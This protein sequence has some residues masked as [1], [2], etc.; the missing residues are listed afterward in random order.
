MK[1]LSYLNKYL[2]KYRGRLFLGFI[3]IL[4]GNLFNVLAPAVASDGIDFLIGALEQKGTM[5]LPGVPSSITWLAEAFQWSSAPS[6]AEQWTQRVI[7]IGIA[8]AAMYLLLYLIKG[9]FLF[10]QRQTLIVMSRYIEFD[11][12]NEIYSKYQELDMAFYKANRTGDLMNRI[13]EDVN[14]VRMYLGPAIMYTI[15][16]VV[17]LVLCVWMMWST[18]AE[19][20]MYT[21][22]PMPFMMLLIY[23]VSSRINKQTEKV[24]RQQSVLSTIV[25]ENISGI[26]VLKAFGIEKNVSDFFT[27]N[28]NAY[29]NKQL[30]LVKVDA[31][32]MPV[33]W[34]LV[35][36]STIMAVYM[37]S[38]KVLSH[39]VTIGTIFQF[40]L[41]V[42]LLTW[43]FASVGW[44][45]SLVQKAE[46]S[47]GRIN[48]FLGAK[49]GIANP[50][51]EKLEIRGELVFDHVSLTYPGTGNTVLNDISFR[52]SAGESIGITGR[53]GSGKSSVANL[54]MRMYDP[55]SGE[56]RVDGK[57]LRK[58]NLY[59]LR[60]QIGY[61]PQE[62]FLFSDTIENNIAFGL[63]EDNP[64]RIRD[65]ARA[66]DIHETI[67]GFPQGYDTILGE[68]GINL[69]GGQKQRVAIARALA[70]KP[71]ILLFDDCLSA[72]DT[73]TEER[74]LQSLRRESAG[75]TS[76]IISH[77]ISSLKHCNSILFMQNGR[78]AEQGTHEELLR[79]GGLYARMYEQQM[80][81]KIA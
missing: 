75:V 55:T 35:G 25:Q 49:P 38:L 28:S 26:R 29:R 40:V 80:R 67:E 23:L 43:P 44:V 39:E 19:L 61:V 74:I 81:E 70:R 7:G 79:A 42:N 41:Y 14:R 21:L 30:K 62:V 16:L 10:Y 8:V 9:V 48:E 2:W 12:K 32:F 57:D 50:T 24:Q 31:L 3:F 69:S 47:Q 4:A 65:V 34:L 51:N 52:A 78:I 36:L 64:Q 22:I 45:T 58:V 59:E 37:G 20:T 15:N 46:A 13:S 1:H 56:I 6:D 63:K 68:R 27:E 11:L 54:I 66:A 60:S 17:L 76:F 77:R 72:V 71:A 5:S 18:D 33:I 73:E 53:T